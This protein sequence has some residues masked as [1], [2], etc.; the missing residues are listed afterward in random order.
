MADVLPYQS[1]YDAAC[2]CLL[3]I[4]ECVRVPRLIDEH[5]WPRRML[6]DFNMWASGSGALAQEHMSLDRRLK[7]ERSV[8]TVVL[9]LLCL[10]DALLEDCLNKGTVLFN[11]DCRIQSISAAWCLQRPHVV[12]K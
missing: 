9:G 8:R 11:H 10:L 2:S 6:A 12:H 1:I 3:R 4:E 5:E 7:D